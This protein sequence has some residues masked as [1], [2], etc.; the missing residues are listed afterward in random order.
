MALVGRNAIPAIYFAREF[1][2]A[3]G[4]IS[5]TASFTGKWRQVGIYAGALGIAHD[6]VAGGLVP[7]LA[8][9]DGNLTAISILASELDGKRQEIPMKLVPASR[10]RRSEH[11][12]VA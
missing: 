4:L 7:S 5:Y 1:V 3:G 12:G 10:T 2:S 8:C 6:M 9:A 11:E